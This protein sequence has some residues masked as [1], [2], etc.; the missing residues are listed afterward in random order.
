[1]SPWQRQ[2]HASHIPCP[3]PPATSP[4]SV[5]TAWVGSSG[6]I[7]TRCPVLKAIRWALKSTGGLPCSLLDAVRVTVK[8]ASGAKEL[9][10]KV[11]PPFMR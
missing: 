9:C 2:T 7:G 4:C 8:T 3:C 1:M 11:L 10:D 5:C 6:G